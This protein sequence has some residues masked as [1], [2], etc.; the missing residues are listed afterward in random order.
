MTD[1]HKNP[2]ALTY[3]TTPST[4][5]SLKPV[6]IDKWK[7]DV[8]PTFKHYYTE[9]YNELVRQFQELVS[10]YDTNQMC[11][12]ASIGFKPIMG[13]SY[14]LY[15]KPDGTRFFSLVPPQ[16]AFWGGYVGMFKLNAQYAWERHDENQN[17]NN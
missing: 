16:S 6:E 4:P 5:A 2:N 3:G 8:S 15:Q 7:A 10:D 13:Q 11:Y 14:H 1:E 9:R 12:E 17:D